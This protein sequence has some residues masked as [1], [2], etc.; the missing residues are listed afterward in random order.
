MRKRSHSGSGEKRVPSIVVG[1]AGRGEVDVRLAA[2]ELIH[3]SRAVVELGRRI[4]LSALVRDVGCQL[5]L[6]C[7]I[8][9]PATADAGESHVVTARHMMPDCGVC[10]AGSPTVPK[11]TKA[12][13]ID[14]VSIALLLMLEF[15][16]GED[17]H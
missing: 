9:D 6:A 10:Y 8:R 2:A 7:R 17:R 14:F 1:S 4:V 12:T 3:C 16:R 13:A 5:G 11:A 15:S